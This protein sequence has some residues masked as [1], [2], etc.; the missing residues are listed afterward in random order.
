M[1]IE[2]L[3]LKIIFT[4]IFY[5]FFFRILQIIRNIIR[6]IIEKINFLSYF[7]LKKNKYYFN[8]KFLVQYNCE[9]SYILHIDSYIL[10]LLLFI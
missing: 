1:T 6:N 2:Y 10:T 5:I 4:D 3:F 7:Y 8:K 9:I